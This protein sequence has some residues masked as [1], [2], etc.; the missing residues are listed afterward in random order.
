MVR[1]KRKRSSRYKLG[2]EQVVP[3]FVLYTLKG[4][5]ARRM[6]ENE[7]LNNLTTLNKK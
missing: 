2:L 4:E 5:L 6:K 3:L 7:V 1:G